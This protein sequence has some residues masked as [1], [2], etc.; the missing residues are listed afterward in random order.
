MKFISINGRIL[1]YSRYSEEVSL[2]KK[3]IFAD[4]SEYF[5]KLGFEKEKGAYYNKRLDVGIKITAKKR[6]A[7]KF[8]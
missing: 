6:S 8:V 2:L 3:W 4:L 7:K 1:D 5:E